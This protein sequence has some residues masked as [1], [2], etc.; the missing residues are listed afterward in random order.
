MFKDSKF[1]KTG[2][3]T[4][5]LGLEVLQLAGDEA[6]K[7]CKLTAKLIADIHGTAHG[8]LVLAPPISNTS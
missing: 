3:Y 2:K 5:V 1:V 8:D 6:N 4:E 7:R